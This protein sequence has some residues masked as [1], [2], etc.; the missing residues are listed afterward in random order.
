MYE[1]PILSA[2]IFGNCPCKLYVRPMPSAAQYKLRHLIKVMKTARDFFHKRMD[3]TRDFFYRDAVLNVLL[4]LLF[5]IAFVLACKYGGIVLAIAVIIL[6]SYSFYHFPYYLFRKEKHIITGL[7]K[8]NAV[9]ND[10]LD[11]TEA[12]EEAAFYA[13]YDDIDSALRKIETIAHPWQEFTEHVIMPSDSEAAKLDIHELK[14]KNSIPPISFFNEENI[15]DRNIDM[16]YVESVSGKLVAIGILF[17]FIGL[18]VGIYETA[19]TL[20]EIEANTTEATTSLQDL[21]KKAGL[22]FSSSICGIVLSILFSTVEKRRVVVIKEQINQFVDKLEKSLRLVT[23]EQMQQD[24]LVEAKEQN[25][26]LDGFSNELVVALNN[27]L[28]TSLQDIFTK[29]ADDI[30]ALRDIQQ[31]FSDNLIQSLSDKLSGGLQLHAEQ[32]QQKAD[33]AVEK[34]RQ[35]FTQLHEN[36]STHNATMQQKSEEKLSHMLQHIEQSVTKLND[37]AS[38]HANNMQLKTD[39]AVEKTRQSFTQLHDSISAHNDAIQQ[40]SEERLAR[41]MQLF[42]ELS[43]SISQANDHIDKSLNTFRELLDSSRKNL[44][45]QT[46]VAQQFNRTAE[47]LQDSMGKQLEVVASF[48]EMTTAINKAAE[49]VAT[50]GSDTSKVASQLPQL[51][52]EIEQTTEKFTEMWH[53]FNQ[54]FTA[55][56]ESMAKNFQ[57]FEKCINNFHTASENYVN[58]MTDKFKQAVSVLS[59]GIHELEES[60]SSHTG[61]SEEQHVTH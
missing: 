50:A 42:D 39:E 53:N 38:T 10:N 32:M 13:K 54:K 43:T 30:H 22:A 11:H 29:I 25:K 48:G 16:R 58:S 55:T 28:T 40:Q 5:I 44:A 24:I 47:T 46:E 7:K 21:L 12:G 61:E 15:I 37:N 33:E 14:V 17:T 52:T 51:A 34:T 59:D 1:Q 36:I 2:R 60:F 45:E 23:S 9:L 18:S 4:G 8:A 41:T 27:A 20:K 26:K 35:S 31:N 6:F 49:S 19:G 3:S 57:Y 56:D